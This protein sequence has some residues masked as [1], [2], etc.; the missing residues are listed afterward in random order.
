MNFLTLVMQRF[1]DITSIIT[2]NQNSVRFKMIPN[3]VL[4]NHYNLLGQLV[5]DQSVLTNEFFS[6]F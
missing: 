5:E 6:P 4:K 1:Y 2:V 3:R